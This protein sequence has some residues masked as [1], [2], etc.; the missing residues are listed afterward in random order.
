MKLT[1]LQ[2]HSRLALALLIGAAC[3]V[4]LLLCAFLYWLVSSLGLGVFYGVSAVSCCFGAWLGLRRR[5]LR[6][7]VDFGVWAAFGASIV[8]AALT[9]W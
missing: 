6:A 1:L 9:F 2:R 8:L 5:S 7:A 3:L 4:F